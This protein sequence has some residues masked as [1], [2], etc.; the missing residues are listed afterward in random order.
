MRPEESTE[1]VI[2]YVAERDLE[3]RPEG[4]NNFLPHDGRAEMVVSIHRQNGFAESMTISLEA[5]PGGLSA[6]GARVEAGE[7]Q[8]ELR[9][10][11]G[12]TN[13]MIGP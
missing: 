2:A 4:A 7:N 8:V 1:L 6:V 9:L 12:G 10:E 11:S 5:L 3:V 13:S